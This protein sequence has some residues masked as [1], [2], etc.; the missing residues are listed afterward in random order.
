MIIAVVK[1]CDDQFGR[2]KVIDGANGQVMGELYSDLWEES[3]DELAERIAV[4]F[5]E[6]PNEANQV[7]V[8][9]F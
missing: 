2:V 3:N 9:E 5:L 1:T 4:K 7:R 8:V 6:N